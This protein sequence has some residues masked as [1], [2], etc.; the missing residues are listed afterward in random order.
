MTFQDVQEALE[1]GTVILNAIGA[2]VPKLAAP[3]LACT[4]A[5]ALPNAI[6]L[7]ITAAGKRTSAPPHTDRQDVVVF[8]TSGKKHWRVFAPPDP[9]LKPM[10]DIFAR[11]KGDDMLPLHILLDRSAP[12]SS[13]LL[14]ETV[15]HMGDVLFIPAA[16]PHTTNTA[17]TGDAGELLEDDA[18]S[19]HL[20]FNIDTH[21]WELDYL[22]AR[23]L[24]LKRSGVQDTVL[25]QTKESDNRYEG[26]VNQLPP[27]VR[28][29]LFQALPMGLL[30]DNSVAL[31]LLKDATAELK[32]ISVAVDQETASAVDS[33]VWEDTLIR[34][35]EQGME[36]LETHRDMYLAALQEGKTREAE[37]AMTA[38][39]TDSSKRVMTAE[40]MQR[41]S[42]FRVK[43]FYEKIDSSKRSLRDWSYS[44]KSTAEQQGTV[45]SGASA[46]PADWAFTLPV[47]VGDQVEADLG[48]AFFDATVKR[49]A[50]DKYDVLFFDGDRDTLTRSM[51]K[52]KTPPSVGDEGDVDTSRMTPKQLKRWRKEQGKKKPQ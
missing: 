20:T 25:G 10:A 9:A 29:D 33:T 34:L 13:E 22:S 47:K 17:N 2:H 38:H 5:T 39:L 51:I 44:A 30:E 6:N 26:K 28:Q 8:Q 11:G 21:I 7:Y 24:A 42:L 36:L 23:R 37:D 16:F 52:L 40:R 19:V 3:S 32:R 50:G 48:G 12:G 43:K 14:L 46:L 18:T 4:D 27:Q 1:T 41:L 31:E 15:L 45:P 49:V 35:R